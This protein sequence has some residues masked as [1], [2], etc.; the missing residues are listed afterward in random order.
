MIQAPW[1][2]VNILARIT[3]L[4]E[5]EMEITVGIDKELGDL[6]ELPLR[7]KAS[8]ESATE[9]LYLL[10]KYRRYLESML[11]DQERDMEVA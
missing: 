2:R 3:R 7:F 8:F 9:L 4:R 1:D 6:S 5:V 11:K 10:R